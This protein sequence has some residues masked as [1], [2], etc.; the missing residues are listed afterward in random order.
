LKIFF[1]YSFHFA[2]ETQKLSLI[3]VNTERSD[4]YCSE[5]FREHFFGGTGTLT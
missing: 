4:C 1:S 5:A 3:L 2:F